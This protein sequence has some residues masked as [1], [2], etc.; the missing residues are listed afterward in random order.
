MVIGRTVHNERHPDMC[1]TCS[2]AHASC[3][4]WG[5]WNNTQVF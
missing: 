1:H 3:S 5:W 2:H 4:E